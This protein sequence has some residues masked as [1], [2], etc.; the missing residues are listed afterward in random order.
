MPESL[1]GALEDLGHEVDS[2][3]DLKL[4]GIDN[5]TL[6]RQ[7]AVGYELCF[8]RDAGFAH[9]VR[10]MRDPSQVKVLHV[11]ILQQRVESFVPAFINVFQNSDWSR[12]SNGDDWP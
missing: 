10:Q 3:N 7:V 8:T 11:T 9:N 12:Y 1:A 5:G 6:Y 2:V 4:K